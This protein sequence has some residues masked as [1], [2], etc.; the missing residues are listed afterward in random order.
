VRYSLFSCFTILPR[1]QQ[2]HIWQA[3]RVLE[4]LRGAR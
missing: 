4:G 3:E 1:R 2:R